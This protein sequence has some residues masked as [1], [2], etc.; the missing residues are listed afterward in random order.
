MRKPYPFLNG[1]AVERLALFS[2]D[3]CWVAYES[4]EDGRAQIYIRPFRGPGGP[5]QISRAGGAGPRWRDDGKELYWIA[6][7][8]RLMAAPVAVNGTSI[9]YGAPVALFQTRIYLGGTDQPERGQ[10][11][12]APDGRFLISTVTSDEPVRPI[13]VVQ[14]W[15]GK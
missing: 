9:E 11:N 4:L 8:A 2:P 1:R 10:Y 12:V 3:G 14:H 6:P 5:W 13:T 7:D 15:R